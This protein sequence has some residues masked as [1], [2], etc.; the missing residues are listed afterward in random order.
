M[1]CNAPGVTGTAP[2]EAE[3][4]DGSRF[5]SISLIAPGILLTLVPVLA[6]A[7]T[8]PDPP[9]APVFA[10]HWWSPI[11]FV[12]PVTPLLGSLGLALLAGASLLALVSKRLP[13]RPSRAA[14]IGGGLVIAVLLALVWVMAA[15][16]RNDVSSSVIHEVLE[17]S[18]THD[19]QASDQAIRAIR[20]DL[21]LPGTNPST[22]HLRSEGAIPVGP[23]LLQTTDVH[24]VTAQ[25]E[26]ADVTIETLVNPFTGH[27][28]AAWFYGT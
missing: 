2:Q 8:H 26:G 16:A 1:L 7:V 22:L 20:L 18:E 13:S 11:A 28:D 3:V 27:V 25:N 9:L 4:K 23:W 15:A 12:P 14:A 17:T 19:G 5:A 10:Q 21:A 6:L 24:N